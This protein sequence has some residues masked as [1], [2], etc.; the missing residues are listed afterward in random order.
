MGELRGI[1]KGNLPITAL[2]V[3]AQLTLFSFGI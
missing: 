3:V 1:Y 2:M